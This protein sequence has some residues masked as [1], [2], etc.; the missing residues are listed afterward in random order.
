[1]LL[2]CW[3]SCFPKWII[4][5]VPLQS[6]KETEDLIRRKIVMVAGKHPRGHAGYWYSLLKP[7]TLWRSMRNTESQQTGKQIDRI[8]D[9]CRHVNSF[10]RCCHFSLGYTL[11]LQIDRGKKSFY[12]SAFNFSVKDQ[13]VGFY[14]QNGSFWLLY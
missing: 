8:R 12:F 2:L 11:V 13:R 5:V 6:L 9:G 14:T 1:M 3:F 4:F 10:S 7:K